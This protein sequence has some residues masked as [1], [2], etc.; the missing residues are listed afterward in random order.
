MP[1]LFVQN[2]PF[3]FTESDIKDLF[4]DRGFP[5]QKVHLVNDRE[6][7]KPRGF[8]FVTLEDEEQ[9][10]EAIKKMDQ[11]AIKGSRGSRTLNVREAT[12]PASR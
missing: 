12:P 2:F 7:G 10:P 5:V 9:N 8:G 6:T 1:N 4:E 3:E 11:V